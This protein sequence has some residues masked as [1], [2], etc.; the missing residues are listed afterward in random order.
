MPVCLAGCR[1]TDLGRQAIST[2]D[3][4]ELHRTSHLQQAMQGGGGAHSRTHSRTASYGTSLLDT[5]NE[6]KQLHQQWL[7]PH[8][9]VAAQRSRFG[10]GRSA[11]GGGAG[12]LGTGVIGS[13][14]PATN[15]LSHQRHFTLTSTT[16]GVGLQ[17]TSPFSLQSQ[18]DGIMRPVASSAT[19]PSVSGAGASTGQHVRAHTLTASPPGFGRTAGGS[20]GSSLLKHP[21]PTNASGILGAHSRLNSLSG[22]SSSNLV[23]R[24]PSQLGQR[25]PARLVAAK[26]V[27]SPTRCTR[28]LPA[29]ARHRRC[30]RIAMSR[31]RPIGNGSFD[32]VPALDESSVWGPSR[33][34]NELDLLSLHDGSITGN[35]NAMDD[36]FARELTAAEVADANSRIRSYSFNSPPDGIEEADDA[37]I[38][39]LTQQLPRRTL[40]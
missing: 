4:W 36:S 12:D 33:L 28:R 26:L 39:V 13:G 22:T 24:H 32:F 16:G 3:G 6:E 11:T 21:L 29:A 40:L 18:P 38:D 14:I 1:P 19:P 8:S 2:L 27:L 9:S 10:H 15:P 7:P 20:G 34:S 17:S 25:Q 37:D 35:S 5:L 30:H 31:R 23:P